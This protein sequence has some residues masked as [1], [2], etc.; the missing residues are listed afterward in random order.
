MDGKCE[1][2]LESVS[3]QLDEAR[4]EISVIRAILFCLDQK[5]RSML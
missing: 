2:D 3:H 5:G 1:R 4:K